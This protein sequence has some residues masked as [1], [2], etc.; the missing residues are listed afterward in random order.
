MARRLPPL[1]V[2][3]LLSVAVTVAFAGGLEGFFR[4]RE[5]HQ[6]P[7]AVA[8]YIWD[9][10]EK[11]SGEFARTGFDGNGWPPWE[12]F[13]A[14]GLRDVTHS[15]G[16]P[17]GVTR[18]VFLGDS[19]TM[20]YN[21]EVDQAYPQRVRARL[22]GEGRPVEVFNVSQ[23]GWSTR[24]ER[25]AY[26][27]MVRRYRPDVVV[28]AVCLNDIPELQN[29]LAD[30]PRWLTVLHRRSALVRGVV[31]A[32]GREIHRVEQLFEEPDSA[33]VKE[34][35]GR[36]FEEVQALRLAVRADGGD[37][38][39]AVFPFRFQVE[40]G[41]PPPAAQKTIVDFC[42][43]QK[44]KCVDLLPAL[45]PLGGSAFI[46]YDHFSVAGSDRVAEALLASEVVPRVP[47][48]SERLGPF[49]D[50]PAPLLA[51]LR[52]P[53]AE[54]RAAAAWALGRR[55]DKDPPVVDALT[56]ALGDP[57][58]A[59]RR[60]AARA[61]GALK[62]ATPP[63]RD[64]LFALLDDP[65]QPVRWAA[66]RAL[67]DLG[68]S[69]GDRDRLAARLRHDD[70]YVRGFAA[71]S[72]GELGELAAPAVPALAD[73]LRLPD[74]YTRGGAVAALAKIGPPAVRAV[75]ALMEGLKDADGDRRWKAA[76]ALGRIGP[77][78]EPA[79]PLLLAALR[80]PND[81]VRAQS[82]RALGRVA[83]GSAEV[84]QALDKAARQ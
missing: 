66:A 29:N 71:V 28:L 36:F 37:L 21:L 44:L 20:G 76:R 22:D 39:L 49:S 33:R 67:F 17:D 84:R 40:P 6:P 16:K 60:E 31:D 27:T 79:V 56:G 68:V 82:A 61:L 75:P 57:A 81:H 4:W 65:D 25:R 45:A 70:A 2:N 9:W 38:R 1:A 59:V 7:R 35:M 13:N 77:G 54:T 30:P 53:A 3:V 14:D 64:R 50:G 46:D 8:A 42:A 62:P 47:P 10:D 32:P 78:A 18:V 55:G 69:A 24:Q 23:V 19:V 43:A 41:A 83:P 80:D 73:A 58:S 34:A 12:E 26:E 11:W 48:Y 63:P 51:A 5:R 15:P 74:G 72:L 52:D